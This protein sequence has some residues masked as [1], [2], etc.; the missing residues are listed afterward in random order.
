MEPQEED[1]EPFDE[2]MK[3]LAAE[4][5]EQRAEA[6]SLDMAIEA[7]LVW[8]GFGTNEDQDKDPSEG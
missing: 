8:L 7:N 5:R 3:R 1:D 2:K 4:W 6:E